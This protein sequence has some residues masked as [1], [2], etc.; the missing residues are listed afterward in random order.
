MVG[1]G[2]ALIGTSYGLARF[3]YG[4]FAPELRAEFDIGSTL[5]GVI[6]AGSYVGYC[7]AIVLSLVLTPRLGPRRV[8]VLAGGV[9]TV[10]LATVALAPS[11]LV[12]AAGILVAGSSTGIASPPMAVAVSRWVDADGRDRA[13]TVVNAGTG[14]GVLLSGPVA[15]VLMDDWRWAWGAFAVVAA[16]VTVWVAATVPTQ[17]A[18]PADRAGESSTADVGSPRWLVPGWFALVTGSFL[19]GASSI[20]V[21]TFGRDLIESRGDAGATMSAVA[22]IVLGALGVLG[23][24]GGELVGGLGLRTAWVMAML[25]MGAAT[26]LLALSAGSTAVVLVAAAL[27]GSSY[28]AL[29]GFS[30][31]WSIRLYP[32]RASLGVGMSLFMMAAGQALGAPVVGWALGVA[33]PT[34]VFCL[35]ALLSP[36]GAAV[37]P[38]RASPASARVG[39]HR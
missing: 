25:V 1:S 14:L 13:Q 17:R 5:S 30:L 18:D 39:S 32:S 35:W 31:I 36:L 37:G 16:V 20:A 11:A 8:A 34:G 21:W 12:L 26:V 27:F 4:L 10:G 6:G 2:A 22:W 3:A 33:G 23:A 28:I 38:S 15:L 9:A 29:T 24:W 19:M 7:A